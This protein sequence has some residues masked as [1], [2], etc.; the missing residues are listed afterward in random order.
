MTAPSQTLLYI[1]VSGAASTAVW[2]IAG[3]LLSS[4]MAE[5]SAILAWVKAVSTALVAGLIARIVMFPPGALGD[6]ATPI[7]LG[8][9][10]LG[11]AV[12]F[13]AG[14]HLG[15]GVIVSTAAL[16]AAHLLGI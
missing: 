3:A 14:R 6:I 1:F 15:L 4:G 13:L 10:A 11:A 5:D 9:F 16:I 8:A 7:R 2:R 12:Y